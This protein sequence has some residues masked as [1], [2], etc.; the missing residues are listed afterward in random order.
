MDVASNNTAICN[1]F[2]FICNVVSLSAMEFKPEP[3]CSTG[4]NLANKEFYCQ[5]ISSDYKKIKD[6]LDQEFNIA[7]KMTALLNQTTESEQLRSVSLIT[8]SITPQALH[9]LARKGNI[10][11]ALVLCASALQKDDQQECTAILEATEAAC[12]LFYEKHEDMLRVLDKKS[13]VYKKLRDR[14]EK[15]NRLYT[16]LDISTLL[17]NYAITHDELTVYTI[18]GLYNGICGLIFPSQD[19]P[20]F[21]YNE[22]YLQRAAHY[23]QEGLA[24]KNI[25]LDSQHLLNRQLAVIYHLLGAKAYYETDPMHAKQCLQKAIEVDTAGAMSSK[26][27]LA[28]LYLTQLNTSASAQEKEWAETV[29]QDTA[30]DPLLLQ[31]HYEI[32]QSLALLY[33]NGFNQFDIK[34]DMSRAE[35]YFHILANAQFKDK[36]FMSYQHDAWYYMG[37]ILARNHYFNSSTLLDT[38]DFAESYF[39]KLIE[40]GNSIGWFG[41]GLCHFWKENYPQAEECF[42]N[43]LFNQRPAC[44]DQDQLDDSTM[45]RAI[46]WW[47]VGFMQCIQSNATEIN[48]EKGIAHMQFAHEI[49]PVTSSIH[50]FYGYMKSCAL[51]QFLSVAALR[52]ANGQTGDTDLIWIYLAGRLMESMPQCAKQALEYVQYAA[53]HGHRWAQLHQGV[54]HDDFSD[55]IVTDKAALLM[56]INRQDDKDICWVQ[57]QEC[58]ERYAQYGVANALFAV[59]KEQWKAGKW[60][61]WI[62]TLSMDHLEYYFLFNNLTVPLDL[63][64]IVAGTDIYEYIH[65]NH[66]I[67][68]RL[69]RTL[70]L[71]AEKKYVQAIAI[72]ESLLKNI[73]GKAEHVWTRFLASLYTHHGF[74]TLSHTSPTDLLR[75]FVRGMQKGNRVAG[76]GV[77]YIVLSGKL[78][79]EESRKILK[80]C[81]EHIDKRGVKYYAQNIL[82]QS[83]V[84]KDTYDAPERTL[85][86]YI[87]VCLAG[88]YCKHDQDTVSY[89]YA[90][91]ALQMGN[92]DVQKILDL[93]AIK[94]GRSKKCNIKTTEEL[95]SDIAL[96]MKDKAARQSV[97]YARAMELINNKQSQ[98]HVL[99]EQLADE[100]YFNA[101]LMMLLNGINQVISVPEEKLISYFIKTSLAYIQIKKIS[102]QLH[103]HNANFFKLVFAKICSYKEGEEGLFKQQLVQ[104]LLAKAQQAGIVIDQLF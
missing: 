2:L 17:Q 79:P 36:A 75:T 14:L 45:Q 60:E 50:T 33:Y 67:G 48:Q 61:K 66:C 26:I 78:N 38:Q 15:I 69:L 70:A 8:N 29:L 85:A 102:A 54:R 37:M 44:D 74:I 46:V 19:L 41:L 49:L 20:H 73:S 62:H 28:F 12:E 6:G 51:E 71:I 47:L 90:K 21:E 7:C 101:M 11:A 94:K 30:R 91:A 42:N 3:M 40:Q 10:A 23:W 4:Y 64:L 72:G 5:R 92:T 1:T 25:S 104:H 43:V 100:H 16:H 97:E 24:C 35:K 76:Y 83:L 68:A 31:E 63:Q 52:Y 86:S 96:R 53:Q 9:S 84:Q 56:R 34:K 98:G 59:A 82:D 81:G 99:M 65:K 55:A 89:T 88:Y 58:L 39:K 80:E 87:L 22:Q 32:Y 95:Q 103:T 93:L 27:D 18:L 13:D 77:A 57:A